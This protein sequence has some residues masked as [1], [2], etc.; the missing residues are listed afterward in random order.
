MKVNLKIPQKPHFSRFLAH[1][2]AGGRNM[3]GMF[4]SVFSVNNLNMV[5]SGSQT[6]EGIFGKTGGTFFL[7]VGGL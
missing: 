1:F 3:F 7:F 5:I 2:T 4:F 6:R